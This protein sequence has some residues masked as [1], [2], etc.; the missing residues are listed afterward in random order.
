MRAA[1]GVG[2]DGRGTPTPGGVGMGAFEYEPGE[3]E[4]GSWTVNYKPPWGGRYTGKLFVT[5]R[6]LLYDAGFDTSMTGVLSDLVTV[7]TGSEGHMVIPKDHIKESFLD[8]RS[9]VTV[10]LD[11]G[12]EHRFDYGIMSAKKIAAAI[13]T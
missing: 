5:N 4:L 11:D 13:G 8:G 7:T 9:K 12:S 2:S 3:Q 1:V 10:V 6:R